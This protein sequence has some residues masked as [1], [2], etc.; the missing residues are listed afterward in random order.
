MQGLNH[1]HTHNIVHRDIK[2]ENVLLVRYTDAE[3]TAFRPV[4]AD[5]GISKMMTDYPEAARAFVQNSMRIGTVTYMAP[6]QLRTENID[7][8]ADLWSFGIILYELITGKHMIARRSFPETQREEAYEFWRSAGEDRFP[9]D[10]RRISQPYQQI[11]RQCLVISR[12]ERVQ[13]AKE[14][15]TLLVWQPDLLEAEQAFRQQNWAGVVNILEPVIDRIAIPDVGHWL[16]QARLQLALTHTDQKVSQVETKSGETESAD[17]PV[18]AAKKGHPES[19]F[20]TGNRQKPLP[21]Q[22]ADKVAADASGYDSQ[23]TELF[24]DELDWLAKKPVV[25]VIEP[26]TELT[27]PAEPEPVAEKRAGRDCLRRGSANQRRH[28]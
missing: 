25:G 5:F 26:F 1:L 11:I 3:G 19:T 17:K 18:G 6:E 21:E 20:L 22:A 28:L 13:S 9:D 10:M 4:I 24:D 8:N 2:P 15:L 7:Y 16:Q 27:L 23:Q 14:L 12:D